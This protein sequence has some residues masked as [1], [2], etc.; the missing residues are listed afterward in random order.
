LTSEHQAKRI[1]IVASYAPSLLLFRRSLIET[2]LGHGHQV[3]CAAPDMD[4]AV[5]AELGRLGA[6]TG[7]ISL[8]RT[9]LNPLRDMKSVDELTGLFREWSPDVV[10]GYTPK[11]AIYA[12]IAAKRA[13]VPHI[14][15]MITGLGYAFLEGGGPKATAIRQA[16]KMLY[17]RAFRASD[18]IIFHNVDDRGVLI[19]MGCVPPGHPTHVVR[20]SGVD[21]QQFAQQPMPP[22]EDGLTF[23]MIARLVGYKGIAEYCEAARQLA[24]HAPSARWQLIGPVEY[25]PAGYPL[26]ELSKNGAVDYLGPADDVRPHLARC[27]AYVLPS[28]GE[29]M[30]RTVLEALATGRPVITTDARGCRETVQHG[31]NGLLVPPRDASA[32]AAAMAQ[33]LEKPESLSKMGHESRAIAEREFDVEHVNQAMMQALGLSQTRAAPHENRS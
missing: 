18:A 24:P 28:Y 3:L 9:G 2:L 19:D 10:M 27:H 14:V 1:A 15:P 29:G 22:Q 31:K 32:L 26:S 5:A 13:K 21:L 8:E 11:P 33:L 23:L 4:E 30:P 17:R 6:E 20:G 7:T 25:G 16:T 12:S